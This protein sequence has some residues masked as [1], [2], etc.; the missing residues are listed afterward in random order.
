L[1]PRGEPGAVV[2]DPVAAA[3]RA[4]EL[5]E[6]GGIAADDGSR[7]ELDADSLCLHGDTPGA[8]AIARAVRSALEGAGV[9][10]EAFA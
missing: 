2:D 5:A 4:L 10:I 7:V 1:V 3:D 6:T 9:G 8:V